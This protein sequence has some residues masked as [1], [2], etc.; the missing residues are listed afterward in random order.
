MFALY[1]QMSEIIY[2]GYQLYQLFDN[3]PLYHPMK[4]TALI[5]SDE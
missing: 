3:L 4:F 2:F 5:M 1:F